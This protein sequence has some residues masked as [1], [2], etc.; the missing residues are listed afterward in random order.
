MDPVVI[1]FIALVVSALSLL[2][3]VINFFLAGHRVNLVMTFGARSADDLI[4]APP[5]DWTEDLFRQLRAQGLSSEVVVLTA[6]NQGR[7]AVS[8]TSF[9]LDFDNGMKWSS[10]ELAPA[11]NLPYRLEPHSD[12]NWIAPMAEL[13]SILTS[14]GLGSGTIK[15]RVRLATGKVVRTE[16]WVTVQADPKKM[17]Q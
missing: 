15:G 11:G 16:L 12:I 14:L 3:N 13:R 9:Q 17:A 2:W 10:G 5:S 8:V 7:T 4:S 1:S 6:M